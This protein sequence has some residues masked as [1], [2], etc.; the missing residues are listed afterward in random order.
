MEQKLNQLYLECLN[1]LEKIGIKI[2]NNKDVGDIEIHISKRNNKRYGACKQEEPD[3]S[4]MYIEKINRRKVVKYWRYKRHII[5]I[6]PWVMELDDSIIKNTIMHEII[7]CLPYC[8]NHGE[9]FKQ[10][11]KYINQ[12]LGYDISRVRKQRT[13]LQK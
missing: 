3:L 7:H 12:N 1:E 9:K 4:T 2:Q 10:Y 8:N 13:R 6:S 11:A 5:E